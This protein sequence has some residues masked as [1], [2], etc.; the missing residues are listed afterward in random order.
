M[1][2]AEVQRRGETHQSCTV[3]EGRCL[4]QALGSLCRGS[5]RDL[6]GCPC[7]VLVHSCPELMEV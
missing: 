1:P 7:L 2:S 6:W 3:G 4:S 5:N